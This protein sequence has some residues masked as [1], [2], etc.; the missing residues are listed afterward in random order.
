MTTSVLGQL[1]AE[2]LLFR[3]HEAEQGIR[4]LEQSI[5]S[6]IIRLRDG[7]K[8]AIVSTA[9]EIAC[10]VP[11]I[12]STSKPDMVIGSWGPQELQVWELSSS[13]EG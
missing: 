10:F 7:R 13:G 4:N 5:Q 9:F 11:L 8:V 2:R 1:V 6:I 3:G 12:E